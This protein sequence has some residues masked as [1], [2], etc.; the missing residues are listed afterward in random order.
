MSQAVKRSMCSHLVFKKIG[1][2]L[3]LLG[4]IPSSSWAQDMNWPTHAVRLVVSSSAGGGTDMYA[5][6]L[7]QALGEVYKQ[8]FIVDNKPGAS[9]NIGAAWVAHSSPDG[10]TLLVSANTALTINGSLYKNLSYDAEKDF[11]P[12]ARVLGPLV[13]VVPQGSS[14]KSFQDLIDWGKKEPSQLSFGSAGTGSTTYLG[15]RMIEEKTGAQFLHVPYKGVA[16]AYQD[17]LAGQLKFMLPDTASS[18]SLINSGKLIPLASEYKSTLMPKLP[19][20]AELGYPSLNTHSSFSL[21]APS[22]TPNAVIQS[23]N[24]TLNT[25]SQN[26]GFASKLQDQGLMPETISTSALTA[27]MSKERS[28]Y[29]SLIKRNN[30]EASD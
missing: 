15:V 22:G 9:G 30:I 20:F 23:L 18:L 2:A 1:L 26:K 17:L 19:S 7:S 11:T 28:E 14:I 12:I 24:Q 29:A 4:V 27:S 8:Q 10:Y 13:L 3:M 25:L 6:I 16:P 5:R 21:V